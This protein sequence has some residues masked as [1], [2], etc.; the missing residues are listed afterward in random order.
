[1]RR[2][3]R[4]KESIDRLRP[5]FKGVHPEQAVFRWR[6]G[7]PSRWP[8]RKEESRSLAN[9]RKSSQADCIFPKVITEGGPDNEVG[10]P[11]SEFFIKIC[12]KNFEK[13]ALFFENC[14]STSTL[15]RLTGGKEGGT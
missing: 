5:C 12:M 8:K 10:A 15:K 3:K 13:G 1:M 2:G 7:Y 11:F 9:S 4:A 14:F 6:T